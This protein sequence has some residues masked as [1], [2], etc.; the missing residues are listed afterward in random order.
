MQFEEIRKVFE[1]AGFDTRSYSGRS[2]YGKECLGVKCEDE[3]ECFRRAIEDHLQSVGNLIKTLDF[4]DSTYD[5]RTD[6]LGQG[7]ILYFPNILW[8]LD[9]DE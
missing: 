4:I 6:D 2:M 8:E 5:Y 7:R 9:E 1:E 3:V